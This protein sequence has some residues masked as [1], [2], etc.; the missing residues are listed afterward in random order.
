M[1]QALY[2]AQ[3]H[4]KAAEHPRNSGVVAWCALDYGSIIN[5]YN[6]VK[7]PGVV[8]GFRV[9]K[10]GASFYMAQGDAKA[11]AVI[12]P[13][14]YWDFGANTPRGPGRGAMIFSNCERLE[15]FVNGKL[16]ARLEPDA[17][18]FPHL[19][20]APFVVDL[21]MD[22]AGRPD[23]RID[24][25]VGG[26]LALSRKFSSDPAK[27]KLSFAADDAELV[28]DGSDATRLELRVTD[29][30]GAERAFASGIIDF[31]V[32]GPG[33]IVGDNP[34]SLAEGGG[35]GAVWLRT[36]PGG[37]G[38]ITVTAKN[39]RFGSQTLTVNVRALPVQVE[40]W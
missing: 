13:N 2:H 8:D 29:E 33:E 6:M 25:Y 4:N 34:L 12:A 14:F 35:V 38:K 27:D 3:A 28:G 30:F 26:K 32:S 24:G 37:S 18:R 1:N 36:K 19:K 5:N 31:E 40:T 11:R 15:V 10:L 23:L 21:D 17:G 7:C 16:H 20:H 22:G 39:R 9:P